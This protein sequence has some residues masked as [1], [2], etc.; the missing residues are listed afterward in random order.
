[1]NNLDAMH[2][3][4]YN[5]SLFE[6]SCN[7]YQLVYCQSKAP[8]HYNSHSKE[9]LTNIPLIFAAFSCSMS[10]LAPIGLCK[11][12]SFVFYR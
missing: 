3:L 6:Y 8:K 4:Y 2:K 9:E 1:M 5:P 12:V 11:P 10:T 7:W